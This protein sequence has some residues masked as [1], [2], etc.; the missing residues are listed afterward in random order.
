MAIRFRGKAYQVR[1]T[2]EGHGRIERT[3]PVG[4][5]WQDARALELQLMR[6]EVDRVV[7]RV[8][9]P[10]LADLVLRWLENE[11][12]GLRDYHGVVLRVTGILD[13]LSRPVSQAVE[14]ADAIVRAS[15]AAGNT[16]ATTNRKLAVLRR[17]LRLAFRRWQTPGVDQDYSL[18]ISLLRENVKRDVYL[19]PD[20][21][22]RLAAAAARKHPVA[23]P[24]IEFAA[25][26]AMRAGEI[27]RLQPRDIVVTQAGPVAML[28]TDTKTGAPRAVPLVPH[29]FD[30]ARMHLPW[31]ITAQQ[32][33]DAFEAARLEVEMPGVRFHDLRH[34]TAS[35]LIQAG[36]P[37]P[38]VR[39]ML[40]HASTQTT[41]RYAHLAVKHVADATKRLPTLPKKEADPT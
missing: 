15:R 20:Q 16:P 3:L 18:R 7:G 21:V 39:D 4:A 9:E 40:G 27:R 14:A 37:L 38:T 28:G 41:N 36:V 30:I 13:H 31:K 34:T 23:G 1:V 10:T 5:T 24:V 25:L 35:W 11:A 19:P 17:V 12:K 22:V 2:V 6:G 32:L 33:R 26:T 29:A 8:I